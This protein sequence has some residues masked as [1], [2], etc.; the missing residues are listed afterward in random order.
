MRI[1]IKNNIKFVSFID[2][3]KFKKYSHLTYK[4][5]QISTGIII[6]VVKVLYI[7]PFKIYR[8]DPVF[9]PYSLFNI[10]HKSLANLVVSSQLQH[11]REPL[12]GVLLI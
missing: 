6:C 11:L 1:Y 9:I 10:T 8:G 5:T 12:W 4:P 3:Q 2:F 7:N